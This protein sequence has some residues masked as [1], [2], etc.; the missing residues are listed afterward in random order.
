MRLLSGPGR[1]SRLNLT[2][3]GVRLPA[4][5]T[6]TLCGGLMSVRREGVS[7]CRLHSSEEAHCVG[8]GSR[9]ARGPFAANRPRD[10]WH[11]FL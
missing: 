6:Q 11:F 1:G 4:V 5:N 10:V 2:K 9:T 3:V 7:H 8:W